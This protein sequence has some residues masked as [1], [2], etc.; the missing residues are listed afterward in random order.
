MTHPTF[1]AKPAATLRLMRLH[2]PIGIYLV[3]WPCWW[4]LWLAAKGLPNFKTLL[5]FTL[6]A[7]VMRSAGCVINDY[8]DRHFDGHVQRTQG[9]PLVTGQLT[10][11][12]ALVVFVA[13]LVIAL[14]LVLLTN[15][16]T[17]VLS[18]G[19]LALATIYPFMKR[20]SFLPQVVLGAAFAWSIPMAF[21]AQTGSVP[22]LAWLLWLSVVLW[23]T[24]YDT[25]YAMAD[26]EEDLVIGVKSTAILFGEQDRAITALLQGL[27]IASMA[28]IGSKAHLG[29]YYFAG[30]ALASAL[31]LWQQW[32]LKQRTATAYLTAFS[33]NN[34]V[35]MAIFTGIAL[36]FAFV[37]A[38][39]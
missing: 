36:D 35:G 14:G 8:A 13:L 6:G 28:M 9:R 32:L 30:L 1:W 25:F 23:T 24:A 4:S 7:A 16:F 19:A 27:F 39:S 15:T 18:L 11:G 2:K 29:R 37:P 22:A 20:H 34:W 17:L 33:N 12:Y 26:R 10:P 21:A 38:L 5:I 31:M 3:L